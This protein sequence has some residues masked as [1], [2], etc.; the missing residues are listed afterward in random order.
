MHPKGDAGGFA[1]VAFGCDRQIC[2]WRLSHTGR[3]RA[4]RRHLQRALDSWREPG[5]WGLLSQMLANGGCIEPHLRGACVCDVSGTTRERR[6]AHRFR[7]APGRALPLDGAKVAQCECARPCRAYRFP[8]SRLSAEGQR[9]GSGRRSG[10]TASFAIATVLIIAQ[11]RSATS[12]PRRST[13]S[14]VTRE[15]SRVVPRSKVTRT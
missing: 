2:Q 6:Q 7:R 11:A 14:V 15:S 12:S 8:R 9:R 13:D 10:R 3:Y 5:D 4:D 1:N